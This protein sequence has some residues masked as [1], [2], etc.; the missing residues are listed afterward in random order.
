MKKPTI[1]IWLPLSLQMTCGKASAQAAQ[2]AAMA[3]IRSGSAKQKMWADAPHRTII[4]LKASDELNLRNIKDYVE[5]R[6]I[7]TS[8]IVD[9]GVNEITPHSCTALATEIVDRDDGNISL[10]LSSFELY[11]DIIKAHVEIER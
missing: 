1:Y 3:V 8:L 7:Q 2:A 4:V 9:E 6:E 5:E 11:K 10:V